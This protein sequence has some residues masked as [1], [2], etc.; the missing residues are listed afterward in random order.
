[1]TP[2]LQEQINRAAAWVVYC[3]DKGRPEEE[4]DAAI[5]V[6]CIALMDADVPVYDPSEHPHFSDET[7]YDGQAG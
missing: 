1:M 2:E 6:L 3:E 4:R 5:N 7:P